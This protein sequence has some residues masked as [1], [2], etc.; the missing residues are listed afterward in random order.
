MRLVN[1]TRV[2]Q[3]WSCGLYSLSLIRG[4]HRTLKVTELTCLEMSLIAYIRNNVLMKNT[5][6]YEIL[7]TCGKSAANFER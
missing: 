5:W 3:E 4:M 7:I 6:T 1:V 2:L